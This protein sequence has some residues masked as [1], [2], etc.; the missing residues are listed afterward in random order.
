[1]DPTEELVDCLEDVVSGADS[2]EALAF[3]GAY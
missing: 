1:M 2:S 3:W